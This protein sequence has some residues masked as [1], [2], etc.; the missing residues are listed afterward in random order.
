MLGQVFDGQKTYLSYW[1]L[2]QNQKYNRWPKEKRNLMVE[3][4]GSKMM[5][6]KKPISCPFFSELRQM[7]VFSREQEETR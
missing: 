4:R 2:Q 7:F 6:V 3:K 5:N 1:K